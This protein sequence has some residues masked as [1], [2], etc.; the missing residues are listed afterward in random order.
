LSR[1]I[2]GCISGVVRFGGDGGGRAGGSGAGPGCR[3]EGRFRTCG[4]RTGAVGL[5]LQ[6]PCGTSLEAGRLPGLGVKGL[7]AGEAVYISR[8]EVS[9][10]F[11]LSVSR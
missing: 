1:P 9:P 6:S 7:A 11:A 5:R 4:P 2:K 3:G 8:P 10:P